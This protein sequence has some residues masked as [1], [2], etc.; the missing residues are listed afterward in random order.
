MLHKLVQSGEKVLVNLSKVGA[1]EPPCNADAQ[2]SSWQLYA[3]SVPT[4][5]DVDKDG[6]AVVRVGKR[7]ERGIELAV[8]AP[9][10]DENILHVETVRCL[11]PWEQFALLRLKRTTHD[12][13]RLE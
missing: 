4:W 7:L 10:V 13:W 5:D 3:R 12:T 11:V 1:S 9:T 8:F 6:I 2:V